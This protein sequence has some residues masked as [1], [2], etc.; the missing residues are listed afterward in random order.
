MLTGIA[1]DT[2][3]DALQA[4]DVL[5]KRGARQVVIKRGAAGCLVSINGRREFL[6]GRIVE[7][8]DTVGA[9]DC[10]A[11]ALIV[12]WLESHDLG[13]ACRFANLASSLKVQRHG[14]Q[15]GIPARREVDALL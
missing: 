7:A 4:A 1:P 9:G 3:D 10:F 6:N 8:V 14:A 2:D 11:G 13:A 15:E 5:H 12:R